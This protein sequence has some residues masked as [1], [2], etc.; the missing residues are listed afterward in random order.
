MTE[1]ITT[2]FTGLTEE[3]IIKLKSYMEPKSYKPLETIFLEEMEG[4]AIYLVQEGT[5]KI[6]KIADDEEGE[7]NKETE[8]VMTYFRSGDIFGEMSFIDNLPRSA[9]AYAVENCELFI[10][11]RSA[12]EKMAEEDPKFA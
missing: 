8:K 9:S 3:E 11:K 6:S 1:Q 12:F 5:V 10:F 2:L 7:E 4:N